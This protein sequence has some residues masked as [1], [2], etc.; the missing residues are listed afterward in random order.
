[1]RV[2]RIKKEESHEWIMKKHYAHRLPSISFAFGLIK[3]HEL[4]GICTFGMPP[5]P[6]EN[7][8]WKPYVLLE[9]NR[10]CIE[11]NSPRNSLSY[12]VGSAIKLLP[13]PRVLISYADSGMGHHGYIYQATNWIYTGMGGGGHKIYIMK[14]GTEKHRR[15]EDEI[16]K[17][18]ILRIEKTTFKH[19]YFYFHGDKRE[20]KKMMIMLRFKIKPYPKG[21]NK[22][23]DA[24][25]KLGKQLH[26][27]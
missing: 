22:R 17:E 4:M 20:K 7:I 1:M 13:K 24:S 12:L 8:E 18:D 14:D 6:Q 27:I 2:E 11:D 23:Y 10:L 9:L 15:H 19:R 3:Q 26:L 25:H 21:D 16:K 5:Q